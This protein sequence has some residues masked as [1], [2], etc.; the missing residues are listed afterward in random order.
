MD[1]AERQRNHMRRLRE[2]AAH[3]DELLGVISQA[4]A[5]L[6]APRPRPERIE[7]ACALLCGALAH[8]PL[9]AAPETPVAAASDHDD[10]G[11]GVSV[12]P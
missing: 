10:A 7:R 5:V 12:R 4:V 9:R 3:A 1:G 11:A 8:Q 6:T 2:R